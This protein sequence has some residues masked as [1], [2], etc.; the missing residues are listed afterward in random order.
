MSECTNLHCTTHFRNDCSYNVLFYCLGKIE[1]CEK[2]LLERATLH[3]KLEEHVKALHILVH[4]LKDFASA[5]AYC[6]WASESRDTAYRQQLFHNLLGV[7]LDRQS[8][9][10]SVRGSGELEMAAV[11]LLNRHGEAFDPV[12]V[13][14]ML[15]EGWSLQLVRPFL[16]RAIRASMH[17]CRTSQIALGLAH[18]ENVQLLHDRVMSSF[19]SVCLIGSCTVFLKEK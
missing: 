18:S 3:G 10:A 11:D 7:Y 16:G 14:K 1:S 15:P 9:G 5:E 12:Q 19:I 17:A 4:Q 2:L 13:L 8:Q 6:I